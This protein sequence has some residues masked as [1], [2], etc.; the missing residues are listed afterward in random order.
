MAAEAKNRERA[1]DYQPPLPPLR[2]RGQ[3]V[4]VDGYG[5]SMSIQRSRLVIRDGSGRNRRE[6]VFSRVRHDLAR[7]VILGSE[8]SLSLTA[9]RWLAELGVPLIQIDRDG[10]LLTCSVFE[11]AHAQLRRAQAFAV[12]TETGL[13]IARYLLGEKLHGQEALLDQLPASPEHVDAFAHA[14]EIF[15]KAASVNELVM[16]ERD[17]AYAYWSA[18]STVCVRL[19]PADTTMAP[20]HW[21][22]FL[23]SSPLT[24]APRAAV[25]PANAILNYLY[26][27]LEAETRIACLT[28]GLDPGLGIVHA[29]VR[30]RDSLAL[31]LMEAVRPQVD[32]YLL[33]LLQQRVFRLGD[34]HE[35]RKGSCRILRPLTHQLAETAV[36]W[37]RLIA[38]VPEKVAEML[39]DASGAKLDRLPTPLTG[40]RRSAGRRRIREK[41]LAS[42]KSVR[43]LPRT[44]RQCGGEIPGGKRAY[45]ESCLRILQAEQHGV[46]QASGLEVLQQL[47]AEGL[48]PTHG[49]K[50]AVR[51]GAAIAERKRQAAEWEEANPGSADPEV[52]K[53][54]ILPLIQD[55]PLRR[56]VDATGLS[57]RYCSLIRRGER[58]PHPRHW[59]PFFQLWLELGGS[60]TSQILSPKSAPPRWLR[61][62]A[63]SSITRQSE[64]E[65]ERPARC[66]SS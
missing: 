20:E 7:V 16:A 47:K 35:T 5:V 57:L 31:D 8:G 19:R 25:N 41:Q 37:A 9:V 44:C 10:R 33:Q 3:V 18:W 66:S 11:A 43:A 13:S 53:R 46:F 38:P 62:A 21:L 4:V 45:C 14:R 64:T 40:S 27:L 60:T 24:N 26:A 51:R 30:G 29:D 50:A 6:R 15:E 61:P 1:R 23:R 58:V 48:D 12:A 55:V 49:G 52:F 34:F 32:R 56:L 36:E 2:R 17:A 22:S 54:E 42:V 28:V 59:K 65:V 39:S 63:V